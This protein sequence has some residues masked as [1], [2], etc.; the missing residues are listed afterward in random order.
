MHMIRACIVDLG[1]FL[2]Y[3]QRAHQA[4]EKPQEEVK[5]DARY[6]PSIEVVTRQLLHIF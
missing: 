5:K 1:I 3:S 6:L 4:A 2:L